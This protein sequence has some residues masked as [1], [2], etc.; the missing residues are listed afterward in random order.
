[1]TA[2]LQR[3]KECSVNIDGQ[4]VAEQGI[5]LL[6]L[7][8]VEDSDKDIDSAL[9]LKFADKIA[10]LRIFEDEEG[11]MNLSVSDIGGEVT[12]VSNF[13]LLANCKK[14][15]RPSFIAAARPEVAEPLYE[16]VAMLIEEK[17]GKR[18]G[19]GVFGADMKISLLN[20]GPVTIIIRTDE[21]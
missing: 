19:R 3:V 2:V 5:G 12:V 11:K 1:M 8:G 18:V 17:L 7:L 21:L 16:K 14:G 6:V 10:G 15:K 13:T 20:D 9:L 4:N